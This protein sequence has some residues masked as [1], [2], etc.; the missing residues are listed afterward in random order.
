MGRRKKKRFVQEMP[1]AVFFKPQGIPMRELSRQAVSIEGFEAIRLVDGEGITQQD[2]ADQMGVSR[3]TLSR[4]LSEA[5][6]GVAA[7][8]TNG[9]AI[10]IEGGAYH[11][12]QDEREETVNEGE[13]AMPGMDGTGPRGSGRGRGMGQNRGGGQ[14]RGRGMGQGGGQGRGMGQGRSQGM[15][16]GQGAGNGP[17][18]RQRQRNQNVMPD[19]TVGTQGREIKKIAIS[20]EGPT[21]DDRVDPRFGRAGGFVLVD[22][23]SMENSYI[24]NGSSQVM[25]QGAGIQAAETVANAHADAILTGYVGPKAFAALS[26]AGIQVGQDVEDMTVREALEKFQAGNVNVACE[27]NA[28]Q[29]SNK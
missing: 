8:L 7:A 4:I 15:G 14:G 20:S 5:R 11:I 6:K 19:G 26:A 21:L 27:P 3:P 22:L 18:G 29:G 25:N 9:W 10:E 1:E 12:A 28:Q 16:Q 13:E 2:A 17:C 23:E 24:D